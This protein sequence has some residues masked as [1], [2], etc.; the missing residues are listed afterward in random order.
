MIDIHSH[1]LPSV[2]DGSQSLELSLQMIKKEVDDGVVAIILTPHVQSHVT[3]ASQEQRK[4]FFDKL[5]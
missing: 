3:K 5:S 1:I 2:D 4:I